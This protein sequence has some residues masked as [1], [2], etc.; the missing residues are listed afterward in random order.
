MHKDF[1]AVVS[2]RF[3]CFVLF[4]CRGFLIH[5]HARFSSVMN[6]AGVAE[7]V[8]TDNGIRITPV[9][10]MKK[11]KPAFIKPHGTITAANSSFL[12][13]KFKLLDSV[14]SQELNAALVTLS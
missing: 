12:V 4:G 2:A 10:K 6:L 13:R 11:M 14:A 7:P 1:E 5:F 9:E 3:H 8:T